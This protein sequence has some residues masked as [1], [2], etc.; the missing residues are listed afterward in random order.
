M[1]PWE[2]LVVYVLI[3]IGAALLGWLPFYVLD[4]ISIVDRIDVAEA[5]RRREAATDSTVICLRCGRPNEREYAFCRS[6]GGKLPT[7][8][9]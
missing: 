2:P 9:E 1:V 3:L 8:Q 4:R 7:D 6:C 5:H